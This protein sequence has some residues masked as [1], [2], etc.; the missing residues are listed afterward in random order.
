[1]SYC[2]ITQHS[3]PPVRPCQVKKLHSAAERRDCCCYC[4][5]AGAQMGTHG[6]VQVTDQ[7]NEGWRSDWVTSDFW[8]VLNFVFLCVLAFLWRPSASATRFAYSAV[9]GNCLKTPCLPIRH[10]EHRGCH[11]QKIRPHCSGMK[12]TCMQYTRCASDVFAMFCELCP[13]ADAFHSRNAKAS[14]WAGLLLSSTGVC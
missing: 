7:Y 9:E 10:I 1:M 11:A 4:L 13:V 8:H 12:Q 2:S 14:C 5:F 6:Y 3:T